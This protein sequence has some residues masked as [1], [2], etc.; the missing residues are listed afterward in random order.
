MEQKH[1]IAVFASGYGSNFDAIQSACKEGAIPCR[2]VLVVSD[3]RDAR[4]CRRAREE[5]IP[6]V[7]FAPKEYPS[8]EHYEA[9]IAE[10]CRE[11]GVEL[12]CLAGYMRIVG[13][14]LLSGYGGR[15]VNIHPSLLPS[16]KGAHAMEQA[17]SAGVKVFGVTIH[18]VDETLDGGRIIAQEAFPYK[19]DS[20]EELEKLTHQVEHRLYPDTIRELFESGT[21][22]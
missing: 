5:G 7:D 17:L 13:P 16:F 14:T 15:I 3:R 19:G 18:F 2:I 11:A 20:L 21:I 8:K 1:S 4:V 12:I 10:R 22:A 6:L 9:I